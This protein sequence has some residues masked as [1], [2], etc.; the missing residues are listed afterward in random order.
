M[1]PLSRIVVAFDPAQRRDFAAISLTEEVFPPVE[2]TR[3][4]IPHRREITGH[5]LLPV[6]PRATDSIYFTRLI[7]RSQGETFRS[8]AQRVAAIALGARMLRPNAALAIAVDRSGLGLP[9]VEMV[10]EE[11]VRAGVSA[12]I[13]GVL[14]IAG[15]RLTGRLADREPD[16]SLGKEALVSA[17]VG[18]LEQGRVRLPAAHPLAG[19]LKLELADYA[20][21]VRE[22]DGFAQFEAATGNDDLVV[23]LSLSVVPPWRKPTVIRAYGDLFNPGLEDDVRSWS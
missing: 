11:C 15:S 2:P 3:W 7:E 6:R 10:R 18:M 20:I 21:K 16:I 22:S 17:M 13:S 1:G 12:P 4:Q 5:D 9:V 14:F 19:V 8:Q 23:A